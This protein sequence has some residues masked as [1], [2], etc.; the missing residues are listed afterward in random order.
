MT[1][2]EN[3]LLWIQT[4][5]G[6]ITTIVTIFLA[7]FTFLYVRLTKHMLDYMRASRSADLLVDLEIISRLAYLIIKNNGGTTATEITFEVEDNVPWSHGSVK[8]L[9]VVREG[10]SYLPSGRTLKYQV[11]YLDWKA[12][13]PKQS[14]LK[15]KMSYFSDGVRNQREVLIDLVQF[16]E[17]SVE[18]PPEERIANAIDRAIDRIAAPNYFD[19]IF[20]NFQIDMKACPECAESIKT[21]AKRCRYCGAEQPLYTGENASAINPTEPDAPVK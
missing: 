15:V 7:L 13:T 8:E 2:I 3:L 18:I 16:I 1:V 14:L 6:A 4:N 5:S 20:R 9:N 21:A 11:G 19:K 17:M 12:I 10:I